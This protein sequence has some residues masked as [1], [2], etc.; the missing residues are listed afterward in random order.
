MDREFKTA[1][2][3]FAALLVISTV[4]LEILANIHFWTPEFLRGF[5]PFVLLLAPYILFSS[6]DFCGR[7]RQFAGA[8]WLNRILLPSSILLS[9]LIAGLWNGAFSGFLLLKLALWIFVP[10]GLLSA[11]WLKGHPFYPKEIL[12]ALILWLPIEF[13]Y[14]SGFDIKFTDGIQIPALAFAAPVL[15]LYLFAI[16]RDLPDIGYNFRW[17]ASDFK[18]VVISLLVLAC[19]LI[20]F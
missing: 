19:L 16:V 18:P 4:L 10:L 6:S 20:P 14:L 8:S 2:G 13:G 15:G 17:Q 12:T 3:I 11:G 9:Y 7:V 5:V 1:L